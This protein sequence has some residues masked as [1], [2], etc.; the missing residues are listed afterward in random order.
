MITGH[1]TVYARYED[2]NKGQGYTPV[3]GWAASQS[4]ATHVLPGTVPWRLHEIVTRIGI[5]AP[6]VSNY[7]DFRELF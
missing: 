1:D 7:L 2:Q 3:G 6:L 5:M 4:S